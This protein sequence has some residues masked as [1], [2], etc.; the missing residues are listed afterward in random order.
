MAS[1]NY[2]LIKI[3][4]KAEHWSTR[5]LS[6]VILVLFTALRGI[7]LPIIVFTL[8]L[9]PTVTQ[10]FPKALVNFLTWFAFW[11]FSA[12]LI[13]PY[14]LCIFR[15][16]TH[17]VG[18]KRKIKYVLNESSAPKVVVVMPVYNEEPEILLTAINSVVDCDYP[19]T[20]LHVFLSFDGDAENELYL[21]T[22]QSL[23]IEMMMEYPKCIDIIYKGARVT[24]SRFPH[25]GKRSCQ[26][27][28]FALIDKIYVEYLKRNDNLFILFIDSDC[29]LDR[30]CIQNF[31]FEMELKP[32]SARNMLAMTG[33][34]TC[35][36][37]SHSFLTILQDI[38]YIHGQLYERSVESA[39]GA[40]T[41]LPG[42]LTM[43][44]FSAF[45]KMAKYYFADKAEQCD[46]LFDFAKCHLGEDR[47]LTHLFMVGA[48][49]A[50]QIQMCTGA[51][52]K[53]EAVQTFSSLLKQRRRWF[54]GS[55]TN[56]ACMLTDARLWYRYPVMCLYRFMQ[57]TIRTTALLFFILIIALGSTEQS[58]NNLPFGFILVSLGLNWMLMFVFGIVLRRYKVW[59]YP[60]MFCVNPF[61]NFIYMTYGALTAGKR[62]WG[63]PRAD[64][65]TAD[66]KVSP[67][68]AI[69]HAEATGDDLN[70]V[71]ESFKPAAAAHDPQREYRRPPVLPP[72]QLEGRF[73]APELLPGGWYVQPNASQANSIYGGDSPLMSPRIP[74]SPAESSFSLGSY[75]NEETNS[76]FRAK[77]ADHE[78]VMT[79][80][81]YQKFHI[82]KQ[83]KDQHGSEI[84]EIP[85]E[86]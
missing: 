66:E 63:G 37:R 40:V 59:L 5:V 76:I 80:D 10:Y 74:F 29:V 51:F 26:K 22:V 8:P 71:P 78:V 58:I 11:S 53:T 49:Q 9:P 1:F 81:D 14:L 21:S 82:L 15:L 18:K 85:P 19:A 47:W 33:V 42:A 3:F 69:E 60:I 30:V 13:V 65:A 46:D 17:N 48:K 20:C 86:K 35:T 70:I 38:E 54:L 25:G 24:L 67:Q 62:T 27:K 52:C 72:S 56:E 45:R 44:R 6:V 4:Q 32:G 7:F 23:G 39:A 77:L 34:I 83:M 79:E 36:T 84:S 64:A 12:L 68:Q 2:C 57:C 61:F 55:V 41:C 43:L 73:A 16:V 31:M 75:I 28:T 50:Y